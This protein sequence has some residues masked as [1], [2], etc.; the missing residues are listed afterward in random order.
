MATP[1]LHHYIPRFLL[2]RF[3]PNPKAENPPLVKLDVA[4]SRGKCSHTSVRNEGAV[5]HYNRL[6]EVESLPPDIVEQTLLGR[7]DSEAAP[8]VAKLVGGRQLD[9]AA[10]FAMAVFVHIQD[11]RTPRARHWMTYMLE[12]HK[13]LESI[14]RL[15]D[16][17]VIE[18]LHASG[19]EASIE[20]TRQK[21]QDLAHQIWNREVELKA[22][23]DHA[24]AGMFTAVE[25]VA[26][27]IAGQMTW[28]V[29]HAPPGAE[30]VICDHPIAKY[31]PGTPPGLGIGWRSSPNVEVTMPVDATA[32]LLLTPGPPR[33]RHHDVETQDVDDVN[34]RTYAAAE[35]SIYGRTQQVVQGVRVLAKKRPRLVRRYAVR[36]PMTHLVE[37][38]EGSDV[39]TPV[40]S[41]VPTG[42][43][44]RRP[45]WPMSWD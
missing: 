45:R 44:R 6:D 39:L 33:L 21:A 32:A 38:T 35:W 27:M 34:L 7:I 43:V 28:H 26:P 9:P 16:P 24:V 15:N 19:G 18:E 3:S 20:E 8:V 14:N 22:T 31:D 4:N 12:Q 42:T 36:P 13:R 25:D 23:H 40:E 37:Q 5:S 1:K 17:A 2:A 29:L 41:H 10:R 30:F 11:R